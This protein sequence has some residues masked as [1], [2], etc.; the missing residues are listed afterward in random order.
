MKRYVLA[1][2]QGTTS[3]RA[4]LVDR[5]GS[6]VALVSQPFE[7]IY[8]QPGWV[9]HDPDAIWQ[10]QLW[11][12]REVLRQAGVKASEIAALGITNQRE[13][14]LLWDRASGRPLGNA[15]VWQCR[16]T[17][18]LCRRLRESGWEEPV[19]Q[20]TGLVI[21]PYFS[22]TKFGWMLEH[23]PKARARA[24]RGEVAAGTVDTW[25]LWQLTAGRVH[26]TDLSNAS[27]TMLFDIHRLD[28]DDGLL[29]AVGVP[30]SVLPQVLPSSGFYGYTDAKLFGAEVPIWGVAGDQQAALFG[31]AC[32]E[33]GTAKATYGTGAFLLM[34]TGSKAAAS[35]HRMLTTIAWGR[36]ERVTY[37]LEG[38]LF[39]AG[40]A[41]QWLRDELGLITSAEES[42]RL[43]ASVPD[44]AGVYFVPAFVGLGA[45]HWDES[46]RGMI[47]GLTRGSG[48]AHVVRAA[49]EAIAYQVRDVFDAMTSDAEA[50]LEALRVDGGASANDFLM[51][52]QA[53]I[54]GVP[55]ER[56]RERESTVLGAAYLA[57]LAGGFWP[58][59]EDLA[60]RRRVERTFVPRMSEAERREKYAGWLQAIARARGKPL[61]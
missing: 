45:P 36:G 61:E 52:F 8:P 26:A 30:R 4:A 19:R 33:P 21:D 1:L 59:Q 5:A 49:L 43:A 10:S 18:D 17:A 16:R 14:A 27:R 25:L 23:L 60:A 22:A 20:K 51:Q 32:F 2:D 41:V 40:A 53:D 29:D 7:Q 47:T 57:G 58:S 11:T 37:A 39:V 34:N 38:S 31:Q 54:L 56:P 6:I 3:S 15:I 44:T 12:A 42:E 24:E 55:V 13:T 9:E 48:R 35:R 50:P 28:W 46:A